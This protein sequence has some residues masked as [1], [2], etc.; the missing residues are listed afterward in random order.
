MKPNMVKLFGSAVEFETFGKSSIAYVRQVS[1]SDMDSYLAASNDWEDASRGDP[2]DIDDS[3]IWG[4]FGADGEPIAFSH[5]EEFLTQNA[6]E[7]DLLTV[8]VQ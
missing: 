2:T 3:L 8:Q 7:R 1:K 6:A 4:L 5:E